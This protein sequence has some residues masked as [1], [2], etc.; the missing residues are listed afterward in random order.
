VA[1]TLWLELRELPNRKSLGK[2]LAHILE[3][4]ELQSI[5]GRIEKEH[6]CLLSYFARKA[7]IGLDH[8]VDAFFFQSI[9][10]PLPILH[11][12]NNAKMRNW[13]VVTVNRVGMDAIGSI[14]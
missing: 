1:K 12:E 7:N 14:F 13:D 11:F 2:N 8:K 10:E 9:S 6:R 5:A 4:F 3:C